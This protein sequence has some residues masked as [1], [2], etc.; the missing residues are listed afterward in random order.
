VTE[1]LVTNRVPATATPIGEWLAE[2]ADGVTL[3]TGADAHAGYSQTFPR[4]YAVPDYSTNA[5]VEL[6][7]EEVCRQRGIRT[8]IHM[9]EDDILRC[10]RVR[11]RFAIPGLRYQDA[12]VWRDKY[13][14][15]RTVGGHVPVPQFTIPRDIGDALAFARRVGYPVVVKPRAGFSSHGVT[16]A[17]NG[18]VLARLADGWEPDDV[19]IESF[20]PGEIF[21][22]DG[23]TVGGELLYVTVSRYI[24]NCLSFHEVLPLG[25]VQL[26]RGSADF[27][28]GEEFAI[29]VL[30]VLPPV[31]F[32]PFHLEVFKRPDGEMVFCEIACR[33]GGAHIMQ[34][35]TY[36]TGV[37]PA[38]LW[39]R[40]Q[41]GLEDGPA[42]AR[43]LADRD[44][45][46]GWLLVPPRSGQLVEIR[47][48]AGLPFIKDFFVNTAVP[49]VFAGATGSVDSFISFVVEGRDSAD[50]ARNIDHCAQLA[51]SL[52][53]WEDAR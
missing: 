45:R 24:N 3:I 8:L 43:R 26:N 21:H 50:L 30:R 46:Y 47:E 6:L 5:A 1:V 7:L 33:L 29:K 51:D 16:V 35:L 4:V 18:A 44:Q 32:C 19:M 10:A 39:V 42:I 36:A 25:S 15:K 34:T 38:R 40:H 23:F 49:R 14:M 28:R 12:L 22:I 17:G 37:N 48:P 13:H 27:K 2:V 20:V 11:D 31:D 41:A 52:S 53:R 9:T